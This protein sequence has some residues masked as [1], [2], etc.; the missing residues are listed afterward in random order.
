MSEVANKVLVLALNRNW[1][2]IHQKTVK[3][4][5]ISLTGADSVRGTPSTMALDIEYEMVDGSPNFENPIS[6]RPVSWAEW[7]NLPIRPWDLTISSAHK[8]YRVPTVIVASNYASLPVKK[9]KGKPSREGLF[10]RDGGRCQYS[11][12]QLKPDEWNIDHV[13][14][15]ARGGTDTW[16]NMVT[17][18]KDLNNKKGHRLNAEIGLKLIRTPTQPKP[19]LLKDTIKEPKSPDWRPF[20]KKK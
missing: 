17:C 6:M 2:P 20:I 19:V 15:K 7:V 16:E 10:H 8:Q 13:I 5:I 11:G 18:K 4:A 9:F 14:P 3:D 1:E 12:E